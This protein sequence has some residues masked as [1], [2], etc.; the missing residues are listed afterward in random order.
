MLRTSWTKFRFR[1][2]FKGVLDRLMKKR[3]LAEK[4]AM[5]VGDPINVIVN[6]A[7]INPAPH[8]RGPC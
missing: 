2:A 4:V 5:K 3:D 8:L 6:E 1:L 7:K